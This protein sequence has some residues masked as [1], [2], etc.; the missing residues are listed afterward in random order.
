LFRVFGSDEQFDGNL[1]SSKRLEM[2]CYGESPE[3]A[4]QS[5]RRFIRVLVLIPFFAVV[6]TY[7][8]S[9]VNSIRVAGNS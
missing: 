4:N 1:A 9:V 2:F 8:A 7:I 3:S 6:T 5:L